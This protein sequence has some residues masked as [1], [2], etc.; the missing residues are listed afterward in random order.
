VPFSFSSPFFDGTL[1]QGYSR[2]TY[3]RTGQRP[4]A[5]VFTNDVSKLIDSFPTLTDTARVPAED[6]RIEFKAFDCAI[7]LEL[8]RSLGALLTG[9]ALDDSL[10]GRLLVPN[11]ALH[12]HAALHAFDAPDIVAGAAE[13][14]AAARNALPADWGHYLDRLDAM[15]GAGRTP[16]HD[17]IDRYRESGNIVSAIL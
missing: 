14:L 7:D 13:V 6:G 12:K 5:L 17:M 4:A 3:Y 16:A 2:R 1:W 11:A 15:L 9:L 8:Y 10:P